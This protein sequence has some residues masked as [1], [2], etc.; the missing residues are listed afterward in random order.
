MRTTVVYVLNAVQVA[1]LLLLTYKLVTSGLARIYRYLTIRAAFEC[2]RVVATFYIPARTA[3]YAQFYFVTQPLLW[4]LD[5][6]MLLEVYTTVFNKHKG[7]AGLSRKL[8]PAAMLFSACLAALTMALRPVGES[9]SILDMLAA[10]ERSV[11][12]SLLCFVIVLIGFLTWFPVPLSRNTLVHSTVFCA[13]FAS[14][15][16]A[17]LIR[18][19]LSRDLWPIVGVVV[20]SASVASVYAWILGLTR[21]GEYVTVRTGVHRHPVDQERLMEQLEAINQS[22]LRTARD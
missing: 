15:A 12:I 14:R 4:I 2:F 20:I 3:L 22:L 6:L 11:N 13:Y 1:G 7:I 21:Q 16:I 5:A 8:I 19:T 18:T 9:P 10:L 17:F